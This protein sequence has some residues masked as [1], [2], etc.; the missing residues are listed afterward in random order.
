MGSSSK[1]T[2]GEE[3]LLDDCIWL[4]FGGKKITGIWSTHMDD[5]KDI[6]PN[7]WKGGVYKDLVN[8]FGK[9]TADNTQFE[10]CGDL[11]EQ[12]D[13]GTIEI[14]Q[15]IHVNW[16]Q[17][18]HCDEA[19]AQARG[20]RCRQQD[21]WRGIG[22]A[23]RPLS[24]S[25][26]SAQRRSVARDGAA[27]AASADPWQRPQVEEEHQVGQAI[28]VQHPIRGVRS[29]FDV[30]VDQRVGFQQ[31]GWREHRAQGSIAR[32]RR[33]S[34]GYHG[35]KGASLRCDQYMPS[36][37]ESEHI[38]GGCQWFGG[39]SRPGQCPRDAVHRH[40]PRR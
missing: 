1:S 28:E 30:P 39:R 4:C 11:R 35:R 12:I 23:G 32:T 14:T 16:L 2:M 9:L 40:H 17:G 26:H 21:A 27:T 38:R 25:T 24:G 36:P 8:E 37:R 29:E 3:S 6:W 22:S 34:L 20:D 33:D 7:V 15:D 18:D 31:I 19:G 5:L 13:D 10:H